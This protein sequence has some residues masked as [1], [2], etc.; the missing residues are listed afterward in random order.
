MALDFP[1]EMSP[2]VAFPI[3]MG[4][5]TFLM[6]HASIRYIREDGYHKKAAIAMAIPGIVV[7]LIVAFVVKPLPLDV[8][9]WVVFI[10]L[11]YTSCVMLSPGLI[12]KELSMDWEEK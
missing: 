8:L 4:S 5:C 7:I 10:V 1:L 2:Q 6:P 3:E 11:L 9:K 12:P